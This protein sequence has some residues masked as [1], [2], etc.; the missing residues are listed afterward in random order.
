MADI[1]KKGMEFLENAKRKVK[2]TKDDV[3]DSK[4]STS[5]RPGWVKGTAYIVSGIGTMSIAFGKGLL[6]LKNE[7][8]HQKA[9][10]AGKIALDMEGH[11]EEDKDKNEG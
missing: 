9:I 1:E 8:K 5:T 11:E 10:R 4:F 2:K 3:K 6:D 7:I